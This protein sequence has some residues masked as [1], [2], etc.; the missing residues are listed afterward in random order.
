L[1]HLEP[2]IPDSLKYLVN[3][4]LK[5]ITLYDF[6]LKEATAKKNSDGK[7]EVTFEFDSRKLYA[8]SLGNET[9][10]PLHEWVDI[11]LYNDSDEKRLSTWKRIHV[12]ENQTRYT[13]VADSLPAKAAIDPRRMLIER[14][15]TDNVKSI[16]EI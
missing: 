14:V 7:Y 4:W 2:K 13:L 6:R 9:E 11:G 1:R 12:T 8:D 15:I 16:K 10:Q 5:N 3:D